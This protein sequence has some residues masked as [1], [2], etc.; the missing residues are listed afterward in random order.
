MPPTDAPPL[1]VNAIA[2]AV[3]HRTATLPERERDLAA[4]TLARLRSPNWTLEWHLPWWL[5]QA[6]GVP[7]PIA[8]RAVVSNVLGLMAVGLSD[9]AEDG[10]LGDSDPD[11]ARR[12]AAALLEQAIELY[13]PM[14]PPESP[15]WRELD[16]WLEAWRAA[17]TR[18]GGP[19]LLAARGAPLKAGAR[20]M[21]LLGDRP[22][23]WPLVE[24]CLD[25]A[26]TALALY[27]DASDWEGDLVA[28]RWNAFVAAAGA[29]DQRPASRDANRARVLL[30]LLN[31]GAATRWY[32]QVADEA[33]RAAVLAGEAGCEPLAEHLR[34]VAA[35]ALAEGEAIQAHY[36]AAADRMT[37]LL[38]EPTATGGTRP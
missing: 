21:T 35:R 7:S 1:D 13:R 34:T 4:R 18:N 11:V 25:A 12:L 20:A 6:F 33:R 23:P 31:D 3:L 16:G 19:R 9:D 38:F 17:G 30:A 27:D 8:R 29:D 14:L 24:R 36:A 32:G 22:A 37:R 2:A 5:G 10:E 15:F 26:L 28:G